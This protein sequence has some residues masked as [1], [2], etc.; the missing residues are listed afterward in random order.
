MV[1]LFG[2]SHATLT[3]ALTSFGLKPLKF[4]ENCVKSALARK[5]PAARI[6]AGM[7]VEELA[8]RT[9]RLLVWKFYSSPNGSSVSV[10]S[11]DAAICSRGAR[12]YS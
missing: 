9:S 6:E 5:L 3:I 10:S 8:D 1:Y 4:L 11:A 12:S 2:M 7:S